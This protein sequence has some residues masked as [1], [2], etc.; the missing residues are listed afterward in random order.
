LKAVI[1]AAGKGDRLKNVTSHIPKPMIE[2]RGKPI[3]EHNVNLCKRYG[4]TDIYINTHHLHQ[5]IQDY[6]GDGSR[7]GVSIHYSYEQT[8]L[9]T[10]GAVKNFFNYLD[11]D[12]FFV[13][14]GDNYSD[15]DLSLLIKKQ[16][17]CNAFIVI[18]FHWRDYTDESGVAE[19]NANGR[20]LR[21]IEK[22]KPG[23]SESH[24]VNAGVYYLQPDIHSYIPDGFSDFARDIFPKLLT[25]D[26]P[27]FGVCSKTEVRAFDTPEMYRDSIQGS[28]GSNK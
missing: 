14:Y 24:W 17:Q 4:V 7:F 23:E 28:K 27:L 16:K 9:G 15:Y 3:L 2:F 20:I 6:F 5:V 26:I 11:S 12:P 22:P 25:N 19:F 18:G 10:S 8:L 21:F 1:L 13:I